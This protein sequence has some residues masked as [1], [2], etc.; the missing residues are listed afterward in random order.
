MP[1]WFDKRA[2]ELFAEEQNWLAFPAD[3]VGEGERAR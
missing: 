1:L 2:R 3:D